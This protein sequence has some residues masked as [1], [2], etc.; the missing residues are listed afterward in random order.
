M[1]KFYV[2]YRQANSHI[3]ESEWFETLAEAE[4]FKQNAEAEGAQAVI[5]TK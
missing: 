5:R 2:I 4:T 1:K 3:V